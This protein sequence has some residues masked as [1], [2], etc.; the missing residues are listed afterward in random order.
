MN[1]TNAGNNSGG[2]VP[3]SSGKSSEG[4]NENTSGIT[5]PQ[6]GKKVDVINNT[7]FSPYKPSDPRG[8]FNRCKVMLATVG[9]KVSGEEIAIM[10]HNTKGNAT[11]K[12]NKYSEGLAYIDAQLNNGH[13]VIVSVDYKDGTSMGAARA[14]QAGDHFVIIVGGN[15][16]DGYHYYDPATSSTEKGTS[17][18][19]QFTSDGDKLYDSSTCIGKEYIVTGIRKNQ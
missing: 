18:N 8:C 19:N 4:M 1:Q 6:S 14:D 9:C 15:S 12:T 3:G 11:T 2:F 5:I 13:P 7:N 10:N 17:I 16:T